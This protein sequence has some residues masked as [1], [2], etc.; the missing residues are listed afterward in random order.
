M[1]LGG[2]NIGLPITRTNQQRK[3]KTV[4]IDGQKVKI[5]STRKSWH[6]T[7]VGWNIDINGERHFRNHLTRDEAIESALSNV[8]PDLDNSELK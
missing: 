4:V 7:Y 8:F 2:N 1:A 3:Q 6:G 5:V